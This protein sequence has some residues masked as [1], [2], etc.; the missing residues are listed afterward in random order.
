M[1]LIQVF[2][3]QESPV[4]IKSEMLL[5]IFLLQLILEIILASNEG[6]RSEKERM[7]RGGGPIFVPLWTFFYGLF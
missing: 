1:I 4:S 5:I 6:K 7:K 2:S 3:P